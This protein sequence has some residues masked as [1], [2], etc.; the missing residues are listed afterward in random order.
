[1]KDSRHEDR[2]GRPLSHKGNRPQWE[3][4]ILKKYIN[5]KDFKKIVLSK[6]DDTLL[7]E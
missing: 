1:M 4:S 6:V 2:V 7:K 5:K 3:H